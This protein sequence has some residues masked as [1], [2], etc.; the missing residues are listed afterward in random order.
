MA[1]SSAPVVNNPTPASEAATVTLGASFAK[2]ARAL[3]IGGGGAATLVMENGD[4][5]LFS[6][7]I[8]GTILPV[9]CT[10]VKTGATASNIVALF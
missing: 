6:G 2:T 1:V 8:A 7:L 5:V 10:Q 9:R 3:Y 4:E